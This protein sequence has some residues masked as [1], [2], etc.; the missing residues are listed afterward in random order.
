MC[1]V[2]FTLYLRIWNGKLYVGPPLGE[3]EPKTQTLLG[4]PT[5]QE[6]G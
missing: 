4:T 3:R 6:P 2:V 1:K 5:E